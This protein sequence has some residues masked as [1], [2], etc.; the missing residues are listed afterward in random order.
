M[1]KI[2]IS[3]NIAR[4]NEVRT[5]GNAQYNCFSVATDN[6][7][8]KDAT[9]YRINARVFGDNKRAAYLRKGGAVAVI[10]RPAY[11]V[12]EGKMQITVWADDF[13]ITKFPPQEDEQKPQSRREAV[14]NPDEDLPF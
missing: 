11:E 3:G 2:I 8:D 9:F 7:K 4:D 5:I 1:Q 14:D 13:E 10:G 12:Y 6:G